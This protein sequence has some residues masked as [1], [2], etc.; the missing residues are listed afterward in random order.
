MSFRKNLSPSNQKYLF[1]FGIALALVIG[2]AALFALKG[3]SSSSAAP[4]Q[5]TGS[6]V[7]ADSVPKGTAIT[8]ELV[9]ETPNVRS[10]RDVLAANYTVA[11]TPYGGGA[12][13]QH[14]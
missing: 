1:I 11:S 5:P 14:A 6:T 13:F 8:P 4:P 2:G 9:E 7:D 10:E 12:D 3:S